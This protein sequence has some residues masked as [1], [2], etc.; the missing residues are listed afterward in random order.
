M[1]GLVALIDARLHNIQAHQSISAPLYIE[2]NV[3][4][5]QELPPNKKEIVLAA[6]SVLA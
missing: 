3:A 5:H 6:Q 4:E 1:E 2:V